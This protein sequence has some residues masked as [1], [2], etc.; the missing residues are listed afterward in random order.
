M[1]QRQLVLKK[2]DR[3]NDFC[4]RQTKIDVDDNSSG[5]FDDV[6]DA[7]NIHRI[8][9]IRLNDIEVKDVLLFLDPG[10]ATG[11]DGISN[12]IL[13]ECTSEL[14]SPLCDIFN[15]SLSSSTVPF[16]LKQANVCAV[17]KKD[18]KSCANNYR[19]NFLLC[20]VEKVFE[21]MVHGNPISNT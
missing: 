2:A 11:S 6:Q 19:P 20:Y 9:E 4:V 5:P 14:A 15:A 21:V 18:D 1:N 17:H 8:Y 16:S 12:I 13:R 10:K 3:L 7:N